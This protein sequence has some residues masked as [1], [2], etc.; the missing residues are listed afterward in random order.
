M[1]RPREMN[2]AK[3]VP[4]VLDKETREI[5]K[6]KKGDRGVSSYI[7]DLIKEQLKPMGA[8]E[9]VILK[10]QLHE[11]QSKIAA[12]E[13]KEKA[14]T[15]EKAEAMAYIAKGLELYKD[16]DMRRADD[17]EICRRWIE[18]RCKGSGISTSDFLS[19]HHNL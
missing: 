18:A 15:K 9:W 13:R 6:M 8:G 4:V 5:I 2:E 16:E 7:R 1:G 10:S 11:A 17:P 14:V 12:F 19:F 3:M